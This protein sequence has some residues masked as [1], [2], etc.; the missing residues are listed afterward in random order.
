MP[1]IT[2]NAIVLR[3][4]NF[5]DHDRMLTLFSPDLGKLSVLSRGC[6]R[7]KSPLMPSSEL[8]VMGEF[9]LFQKKES[10]ILTSCSISDTFYPLRLDDYRLICASYVTSLSN[11]VIMPNHE[12]RSLYALLLHQLYHLAYNTTDDALTLVT[13]YLVRFSS[14]IGYKPRLEHCAHCQAKLQIGKINAFDSIAGGLCCN[15][16]S[17]RQCDLLSDTHVNWMKS[18]LADEGTPALNDDVKT[19]F[20]PLRKHVESRLESNIKASRFLP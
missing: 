11:A 2:I 5:R 14:L 4:T 10:C 9:V 15:S 20:L 19:L 18:V 17:S 1:S 6:R 7:P 12:A 3:H 16:C 13:A 8:F